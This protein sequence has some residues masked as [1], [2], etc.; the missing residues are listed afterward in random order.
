MNSNE[1]IACI[2][3]AKVTYFAEICRETEKGASD[4]SIGNP[5]ILLVS[6]VGIEPTT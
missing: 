2:L 6:P 3:P 1:R 4:V 5:S